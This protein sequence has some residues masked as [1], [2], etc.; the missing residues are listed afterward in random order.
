[1]RTDLIFETDGPEREQPDAGGYVWSLAQLGA[2]RLAAG[3]RDGAVRVV[4]VEAGRLVCQRKI[5]LGTSSVLCIAVAPDGALLA[6][7][8]TG[9]ILT[10]RGASLA[11]VGAHDGAVLGLVVAGTGT[12]VSCGADGCLRVGA[13]RYRLSSGWLRRVAFASNGALLTGGDDGALWAVEAGRKRVVAHIEGPIT[14]LATSRDGVAVGGADGEV[15]WLAPTLDRE[16][17]RW[18]QHEAAVM[19][20][21]WRGALL[22]SG[23]EDGVVVLTE[24]TRGWSTKLARGLD[25]VQAFAFCGDTLVTGGYDGIRLLRARGVPQRRTI[26]GAAFISAH[27]DR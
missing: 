20:L 24:A 17:G 1:M 6:G 27:F 12:V 3:C 2:G 7:T 9:E 5:Q 21:A 4:S 16:L 18:R 11:R 10:A 13:D 19:A 14:A 8:R 26:S 25:F 15:R 23:G 22:A